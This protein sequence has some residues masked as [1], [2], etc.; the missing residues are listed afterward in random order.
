MKSFVA[1]INKIDR[2]EV[3]FSKCIHNYVHSY[4]CMNFARVPQLRNLVNSITIYSERER[5]PYTLR[6]HR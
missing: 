4:A 5:Q 1:R 6:W 2:R 3:R